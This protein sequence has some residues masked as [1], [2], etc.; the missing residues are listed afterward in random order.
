MLTNEA[1]HHALAAAFE[2]ELPLAI[3]ILMRDVAEQGLGEAVN[4]HVVAVEI[5][6]GLFAGESQHIRAIFA[7]EAGPVA[8][9]HPFG[10]RQRTEVV[11]KRAVLHHQHDDVI[12]LSEHAARL[13]RLLL[14]T[15][16]PALDE[17]VLLL[18]GVL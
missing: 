6:V 5:D 17:L 12:D 18:G 14:P 16:E 15:V 2:V 11:I 4:A 13:E 9:G 1:I 8:I 7:A 3:L 10:D